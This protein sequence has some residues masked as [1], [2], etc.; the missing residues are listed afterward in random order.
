MASSRCTFSPL[1]SLLMIF[2]CWSQENT[3]QVLGQWLLR[4]AS[5]ATRL[6]AVPYLAGSRVTPQ[7]CICLT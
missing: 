1:V 7:A 2:F 6:R 3:G 5:G 4:L